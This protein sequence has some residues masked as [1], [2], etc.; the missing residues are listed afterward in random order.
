MG[1]GYVILVFLYSIVMSPRL[2]C[3]LLCTL[4]ALRAQ[5]LSGVID[6][7]I[8]ADPDSMPRSIDAL[9]LARLAHQRGLRAIVLKNHYESTAGVAWLA[10]QQAPGLEVF[11]GIA[12]NLPVGGLN[13]TA[14]EN[15]V[16]VKGGY[17]RIVWMPTFEALAFNKGSA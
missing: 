1:T 17:G 12:L 5:T 2:A 6:A 10:S 9:S 3:L 11:G 14:I 8:H 16:R 15:M 13:P 4:P 7:H